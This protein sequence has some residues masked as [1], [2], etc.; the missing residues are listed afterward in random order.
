[1]SKN[2]TAT[3]SECICFHAQRDA[4]TLIQ[5]LVTITIIAV[6]I[7]LLLPAIASVKRTS[8][9]VLCVNALRQLGMAHV[10]FV[11]DHSGQLCPTGTWADHDQYNWTRDLWPYVQEGQSESVVETADT[12]RNRTMIY[13][14]RPA[15]RWLDTMVNWRIGDK[16]WVTSSYGQNVMPMAP[17]SYKT[18]IIGWDPK[19]EGWGTF[20]L[21]QIDHPA[22]RVLVTESWYSFITAVTPLTPDM[23]WAFPGGTGGWGPKR[24]AQ[25]N[26][27]L[28][29]DMHVKSAPVPVIE[30]STKNPALCSF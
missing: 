19:G 29:F 13:T 6:L 15:V 14:C 10:A 26:N 27:S 11:Q 28:M 25:G 9:N 16:A 1:M 24:H 12:V 17:Q 30:Q 22:D 5:L 4:F 20:K 2:L 18:S 7:S 21:A 3:S 23:R 8:E